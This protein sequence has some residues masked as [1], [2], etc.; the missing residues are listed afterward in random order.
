MKVIGG[1]PVNP[2][3]EFW[4]SNTFRSLL[5]YEN[6]NDFPNKLNSWSDS[7]HPDDKERVLKAFKDHIMDY[8]GKTPFDLEYR[9]RKKR[10]RI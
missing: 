9:L 10:R 8:S 1:D 3:N 6:E 5:G 4:W 7:L 2:D